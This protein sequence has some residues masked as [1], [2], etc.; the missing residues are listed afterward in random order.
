[1]NINPDIAAIGRSMV[2]NFGIG[3]SGSS[4]LKSIYLK[5]HFHLHTSQAL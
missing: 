5:F 4:S 2:G 3:I 1:M